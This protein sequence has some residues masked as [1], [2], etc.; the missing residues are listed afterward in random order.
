M[1]WLEGQRFV[2]QLV[3]AMWGFQPSEFM[4][5]NVNRACYSDDTEVLTENGWKL[6][7]D[8]RKDERIAVYVNF[9][10]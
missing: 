5:S 3:W 1:E 9:L 4:G 6:H 2:G 10:D 8:I 7:Q